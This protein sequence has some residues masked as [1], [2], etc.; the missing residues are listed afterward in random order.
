MR[1]LI[2]LIDR[3]RQRSSREGRLLQL[4]EPLYQ[5]LAVHRG[6]LGPTVRFV[7]HHGLRCRGG[8]FAG[9]R[10]PRS[11]ILRIPGLVAHLAGT[12]EIEL[13]QAVESLIRSQPS[14]VINIGAGDGYYAVGMAHRCPGV[15]V[16]A[17]E[18]DPYRVRI[19]RQVARLN[20]VGDRIDQRGA[21]T[22]NELAAL[23]AESGTAVIADCESAER[24]LIDPGRVG[25]L[26]HASL[27][28]EVHE[29]LDS[30]L[31][32]QLEE[33]LKPSHSLEWITPGKRY[34]WDP[35][36]AMGWSAGLSPLQ[37]ET[38][39]AEL[40]PVRTPWLWAIPLA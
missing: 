29:F 35:E 17:Y 25:W 34:V 28:I 37:Q 40:R 24:E 11:A 23:P 21:C 1:R 6:A 20:R 12:Y 8:P 30:G 2:D 19:C 10:Y 26:R 7:R 5:M 31:P 18:P 13:H 14:L 4:L 3:Y 16:I 38:V 39:M 15:K 33:R 22:P 32:A 9:V 36:Y 27:L